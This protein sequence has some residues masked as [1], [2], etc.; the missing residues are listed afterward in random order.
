MRPIDPPTPTDSAARQAGP[1]DENETTG[2]PWLATWNRVYAL[3]L[4]CFAIWVGLLY[5]LSLVFL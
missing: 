4:G 1:L 5:I 3:V 2:L